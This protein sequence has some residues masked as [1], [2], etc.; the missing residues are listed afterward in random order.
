MRSFRLGP[1]RVVPFFGTHLQARSPDRKI[2]ST[3]E[4]VLRPGRGS[5]LSYE[6]RLLPEAAKRWACG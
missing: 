3:C 5:G 4:V 1:V 6:L 2:R